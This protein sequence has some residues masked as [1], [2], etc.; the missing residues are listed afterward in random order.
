MGDMV[1][2]ETCS[3]TKACGC[4]QCTF[5]LVAQDKE[6]LVATLQAGL[7]ARSW[8]WRIRSAVGRAL[9]LSEPPEECNE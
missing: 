9:L 7:L 1:P 8:P 2:Q 6:L 4:L 5:D 3:G